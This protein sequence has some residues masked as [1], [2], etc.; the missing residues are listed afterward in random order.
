[1][2]AHRSILSAVALAL[3]AG[4]GAFGSRNAEL[5]ADAVVA[6]GALPAALAAASEQ[7]TILDVRSAEAYALGHLPGAVRVDEK[8]W[9][10][11]S[12]RAATGLDH[13]AEWQARIGALGIDGRHAVFV[14][15]D[16]RMTAAARLWFVLQHFGAA[17]VS[18]VDGGFPAIHEIARAGQLELVTAPAVPTPVT[19]APDDDRAAL[20][21]LADRQAVKD[22]VARRD[23]RVLDVRTDDEFHGIDLRTN[24]RGGH[25]P[26]AVHIPHDRLLDATG[27]LLPATEL[28]RLFEQAGLSPGDPVIT[29]CDGGG[30]AALAALAAAR[31]GY[32]PV[33]SY[34]LSFG[35]WAADATCPVVK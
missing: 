6:A 2:H 31:A 29:H 25:I 23:A 7:R 13:T 16:G 4:C 22:A 12:T 35:D 1:M 32:G 26:G 10:D 24:A 5:A 28:A 30:R 3:L 27:H 19:F 14:Y 11:L 33:L 18:V 21:G 34:Y 8:E 9:K 20:V 15:D 17:R